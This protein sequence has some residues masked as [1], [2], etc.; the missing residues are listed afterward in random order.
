[1][2]STELRGGAPS[3]GHRSRGVPSCLHVAVGVVT[4]ARGEVL[5][6]KRPAHAHQGGLWEF[7]GGKLE[8]GESVQDALRRELVEELAV[9][10]ESAR[11]LIQVHHAYDDVTVCLD[12]WQV[13][14]FSGEAR[15]REGQPIAWVPADA[16]G[17]FRFPAANL[18]I[19]IA[20]QLPDR[21]AI[22]DF[23]VAGDKQALE[24]WLDKILIAG[25]RLIQLRAKSLS[26]GAY[27]ALARTV[28]LR[29]R[30][31]KVGVMLNADPNLAAR[32]G[33]TGVHLT[34]TQLM[35]FERRPLDERFWVAASCHSG[36][37]L[38]HAERIGVDFTVLGPVMPTK[39]HPGAATLGWERFET[40]VSRANLPVFALGGVEGSQVD[41]VRCRGGQGVAGIRT[42][43]P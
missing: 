25:I 31:E 4:N 43:L 37:E 19:V 24:S 27:E 6:A 21:Y 15:G 17:E 33:A 30:R 39:S 12:V 29:C 16:L 1:M 34:S 7:P 20:A 5:I 41:W 13:D 8:Q 28:C 42:F 14:A 23:D 9:V 2:P 35:S 22:V 32:V 3:E 26:P 36:E 38:E 40:L 10:V 11:P 18:P